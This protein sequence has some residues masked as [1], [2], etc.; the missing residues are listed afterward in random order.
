MR[1]LLV[2]RE[3][4]GKSPNTKSLTYNPTRTHPTS[5]ATVDSYS[6]TAQLN[7]ILLKC[8]LFLSD[9]YVILFFLH[10]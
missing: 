4:E 6:I 10:K 8:T 9:L 3:I 2:M 7:K 1:E 5:C